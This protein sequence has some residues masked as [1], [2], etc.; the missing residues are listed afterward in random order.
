M[1]W[2]E[3][4]KE[5]IG[6]ALSKEAIAERL[7]LWAERLDFAEAKYA[8][9]KEEHEALKAQRQAEQTRVADLEAENAKLKTAQE[10]REAFTQCRGALFRRTPKGEWER[11]VYCPRC[12]TACYGGAQG[13]PFSCTVKNCGWTSPFRSGELEFI[14]RELQA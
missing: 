4:A 14:L 3:Q 5:F 7:V 9:L 1:G 12:K 11:V 2:L 13:L 6:V 10:T 8:S